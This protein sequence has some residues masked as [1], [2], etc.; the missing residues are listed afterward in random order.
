[1]PWKSLAQKRLFY[2]RPELRRYIPEFE[3]STKNRK[4]PKRVKN[5]LKSS[6]RGKNGSKR[7][8]KR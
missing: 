3:A 7:G 5:G 6:K 8:K 2:A 1:M 4:L